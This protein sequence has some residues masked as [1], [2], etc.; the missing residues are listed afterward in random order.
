[1]T[2]AAK[3]DKNLD[4]EKRVAEFDGLQALVAEFGDAAYRAI[5][6][7]YAALGYEEGYDLILDCVRSGELSLETVR[8]APV[9]AVLELLRKFF[10]RR[11]GNQP[12]FRVEND[13]IYLTTPCTS[14]CPTPAAVRKTGLGHKD[15]CF[16]HK[17]SFAAGVAG[18]I[19]EF[20]PALTVQAS[21]LESRNL[22]EGAGC[23]EAYKVV[24][25]WPVRG[26]PAPRG[27]APE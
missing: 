11:G 8:A 6:R 14:W 17:R 10:E 25:G 22:T 9:E 16:V 5:D 4:L 7:Y 19:M 23:T 1:M 2:Q 3:R 15:I 13:T 27:A 18:A 21:N 24:A 20:V 26:A 12:E